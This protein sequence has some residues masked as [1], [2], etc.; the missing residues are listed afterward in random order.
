M[1]VDIG[2]MRFQ[3]IIN[4]QLLEYVTLLF[5]NPAAVELVKKGDANHLFMTLIKE[6]RWDY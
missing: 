4:A 3:Y 2:L 1:F 5:S 6:N